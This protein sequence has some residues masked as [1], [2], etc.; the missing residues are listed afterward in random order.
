MR[1]RAMVV[2]AAALALAIPAALAVDRDDPNYVAYSQRNLSIPM[3]DGPGQITLFGKLCIPKEAQGGRPRLAVLNH[4]SPAK[5]SD[6]PTQSI[7]SC[8]S[9]PA[10]WMLGHGFAVVY[11]QR[12][13]YGQTGGAWAEGYGS[14]NNPDY[15]RA[16]RE[17]ARDI[18]AIVDFA[19]QQPG[20]RPD[21]AVVA[22]V[23]A[24]GWGTI[25]YN[26]QPH[27]KVVAIVNMAGGRG[28]HQGEDSDENCRPDR[29]AQAA[30]VFGKTAAT[31]MIWIYAQNDT[32]FGP[33]IARAMYQAYSRAGGRAEFHPVG[34]H[35]DEGHTL[36]SD[37]G[38]SDV[39]GPLVE[40]YL[41]KRGALD[42][43][44]GR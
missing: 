1:F 3:A 25:A 5:A 41:R 23:S 31:P 44:G 34:A 35:G 18:A 6:R 30:G 21:G 24:G 43:S 19:T 17:T 10:Q 20:V 14:C 42:Q 38:G 4:G 28:G 40:S 2:C 37:E 27:P 13:G 36:W 26:A 29:L 39:W 7:G 32:F 12:R 15:V 33:D 16:G 11:A 9:E 22:G 8:N